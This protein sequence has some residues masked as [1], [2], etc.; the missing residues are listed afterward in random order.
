MRHLSNLFLIKNSLQLN[1]IPFHKITF[2]IPLHKL[3]LL[4]HYARKCMTNLTIR[5]F[6]HTAQ[7]KFSNLGRLPVH[8]VRVPFRLQNC[9]QI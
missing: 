7:Y 4:F 2:E 1:R 5:Y 3:L 8:Y 9:T 6:F